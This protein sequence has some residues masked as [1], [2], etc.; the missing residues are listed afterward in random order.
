MF[1]FH[2][3]RVHTNTFAYGK[4]K[5]GALQF[6]SSSVGGN[7]AIRSG[8]WYRLKIEVAEKK[9][10]KLFLDGVQLG[11]TFKASFTT[12]GYG[13]VVVANGYSNVVQFRNLSLAPKF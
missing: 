4:I 1:K 10:V 12:R 13:G 7:P 8:K 9:D 3:Y 2:H 5:N 6:T 11:S